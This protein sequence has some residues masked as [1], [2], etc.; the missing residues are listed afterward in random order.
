MWRQQYLAMFSADGMVAAKYENGGAK[1]SR[2]QAGEWAWRQRRHRA[3]NV[4]K[5]WMKIILRATRQR[6]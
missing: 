4:E 2:H 6:S 1:A 3:E 5:L